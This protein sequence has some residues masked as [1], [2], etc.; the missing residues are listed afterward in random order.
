MSKIQVAIFYLAYINRLIGINLTS[1]AICAYRK[2]PR[3]YYYT[4]F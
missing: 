3:N 1:Q 2:E 4:N